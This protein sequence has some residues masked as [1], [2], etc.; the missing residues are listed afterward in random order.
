MCVSK[1]YWVKFKLLKIRKMPSPHY[2]PI[3]R[4]IFSILI[5]LSTNKKT[6]IVNISLRDGHSER[7]F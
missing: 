2:V 1:E 4:D 5:F 7:T 6:D 3:K